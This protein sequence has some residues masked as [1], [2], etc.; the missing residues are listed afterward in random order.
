MTYESSIRL[1]AVLGLFFGIALGF[2]VGH[3]LFPRVETKE[4]VKEVEK[5]V[6]YERVSSGTR[7]YKLYGDP[8]YLTEIDNRLCTP[9]GWVTHDG[10]VATYYDWGFEKMT[11]PICSKTIQHECVEREK[12]WDGC[13]WGEKKH[14]PG[15]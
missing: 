10:E 11:L 5:M 12:T 2:F 3:H 6:P 7:E 1:A 15:K 8:V 13:G 14:K 4:V 9:D